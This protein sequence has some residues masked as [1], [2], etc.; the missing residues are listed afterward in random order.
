MIYLIVAGVALGIAALFIAVYLFVRYLVSRERD[1]REREERLRLLFAQVADAIFVSDMAGRLV[2]VNDQACQ[3]TGYSRE[4]LLTLRVTDVDAM[5]WSPEMVADLFDRVSKVSPVLLESEQRRKDGS[6]FPV[7]IAI[8]QLESPQGVYVVGIARDITER[9]RAEEALT[10]SEVQHRRLFENAP[11]GIFQTNSRGEVLACNA[12]MARML[13]FSSPREAIEHYQDLGSQLYA[14]PERRDEF[15]RLLRENGAV[16]NFEYEANTV[17]GRCVWVSMNARVGEPDGE[18]GFLIDGFSSDISERRRVEAANERRI[19]A[20]TRPLGDSE[21]LTFQEL[22]NIDDIQYL[23]DCFAEATGVASIITRTDGTPI[24]RPSNFCR[25]CSEIIRNTDKGL[26]NCI[27]SDAA[28]GRHNSTGPI[29]QPCLS[30]GFTDA[31]ASISV[32]GRYIANWLIGQVRNES[33]TEEGMREYA[34]EIGADEEEVVRAF[35][36]VPVMPRERFERVAQALFTLA[37]QLSDMAYQN[38]QQARFI[39]ERREAEQAVVAS[40][41]RLREL[42]EALPEAIFEADLQLNLTFANRRAFE[43]FGYTLDDFDAGLNGLD[44]VAPED[45]ARAI[46]NITQREHGADLGAVEYTGLRRDG[47]QFPALIHMNG[48]ERD[49]A[50]QGFRG[51]IVDMTE[52]KRGEQA[53]L[54]QQRII[55]LSNRIA[56]VFLT[57]PP[58]GIYPDVLNVVR[59]AL[60][61]R[62][63]F[64]AYIDDE[65][66]MV[67]PSMTREIWD[68]CQVPDKSIV[69]P[70]ESWA[71]LWGRAL[72]E[73]RSQLANEGLTAPSGHVPLDNALAVPIVHRGD[74]I[75]E[76]VVANKQGGYTPED[77]ELLE[78]AAGQTAPVLYAFL[79]EQRNKRDRERLEEQYRQAQKMEAVGQLTGGVAHDFNNLLQVI[80]G[81]TEIAIEDIEPDHPCV[82]SLKQVAEAGERAA[83][84]VQQLLLFSRRQVMRPEVLD[85]NETV[86]D[87][88]KML[89]R[90]LGEHVRLHWQPGPH[91]GAIHADRSM[92]EQLLMNLCLNARD[93]MPDGGALSIATR[94]VELDAAFCK[95]HTWAEPGRYAAVT[96]SDTGCGINKEI[97]E[98]IFEPF[99][100]TKET[101]K[102]T[103]LGLSTVYGIVKQHDG[104]IHVESEPGR[105]ASFGIYLPSH[106]ANAPNVASASDSEDLRRGT[107]TVLLAEDDDM[108][109]RLAKATLERQGYTVIATKDGA[110]AVEFFQRTPG[111]IDLLLLDVVMPRMGGREAYEQIRA[112][113]PDIPALF[114]SGYS[115]DAVHTNFVLHEGLELVQKPFTRSTLLRAVGHAIDGANGTKTASGT[116]AGA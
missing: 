48:M 17:D 24:T 77:L 7:E 81:V 13:G 53:L 4:E 95:A 94:L 96:V 102:G 91:T 18:G 43:L 37:T 20:L 14:C 3:S 66:N 9:R 97:V 61:S 35:R 5:F 23:Q 57:A 78:S 62:F 67:S 89:G 65:G 86:A 113:R 107:E 100:T 29:I 30:G 71:G 27:R 110:E 70:R 15:V 50:L 79:E 40:E 58:E 114:A 74:L 72:I 6:V 11:V 82:K 59:E 112:I 25:L 63:G 104:L 109:R 32:G 56:N 44:M 68:E 73:K 49:G 33:Q 92:V 103:G 75:G 54:R 8:S 46:E 99:F 88:L 105:S 47:T 101:G 90:I 41:K 84:L 10:K 45:R 80:N 1:L 69:F 26:A 39:A 52:R 28:L 98:H 38:V 22:F 93:A 16:E 55:E 85:L 36:E 115:E 51:I 19:V 111:E 83:R 2:Q 108:V 64:F 116:S 31:G 34:R 87:L 12:T 42:T 106:R 76:F 21:D 60:H